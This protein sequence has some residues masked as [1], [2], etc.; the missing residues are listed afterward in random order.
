[1]SNQIC[2]LQLL[3]D[4][5][6]H[7]QNVTDQIISEILT[8]VCDYLKLAMEFLYAS[9]DEIQ[10]KYEVEIDRAITEFNRN[11]TAGKFT[12]VVVKFLRVYTSKADDNVVKSD[13]ILE[14][15]KKI[16]IKRWG[17]KSHNMRSR[18]A[19]IIYNAKEWFSNDDL[20]D[21]HHMLR[22]SLNNMRL[23]S[24]KPIVLRDEHEHN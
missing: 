21:S 23:I 10:T 2:L 18:F 17:S 19:Q 9:T 16:K 1:M 22:L 3:I 13:F 11:S 5:V 4:F 8:S 20:K 7:T 6:C 24:S 12:L 15:L 14:K